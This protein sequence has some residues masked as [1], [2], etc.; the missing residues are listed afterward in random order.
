MILGEKKQGIE[1]GKLSQ[2][3]KIMSRVF[4]RLNKFLQELGWEVD[5]LS[6]GSAESEK[7]KTTRL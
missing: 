2:T 3:S 5:K 4:L 6:T 1:S 7:L